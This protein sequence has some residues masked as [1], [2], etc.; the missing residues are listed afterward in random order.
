MTLKPIIILCTALLYWSSSFASHP[1]EFDAIY[2]LKKFGLDSATAH[3]SFSKQANGTWLYKS[4]TETRGLVSLFRKDKISEQSILKHRKEI[5]V[6]ILYEYRHS[7]SKKNRD[8]SIN[9]DWDNLQA[10]SVVSGTA[11]SLAITDG[12]IDGFSL[13]LKLMNDL[14][15]GKQPLV[16]RV[17]HKGEIKHYE[18]EI[19]GNETIE[20]NAGE[21]KTLKLKRSR[22]DSKRTTIMWTAP[23]LHY[24]PVKIT[25]IEKDDSH[26]T[27]LLES[28]SGDITKKH[29]ETQANVSQLT[30]GTS[31]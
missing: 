21:F 18:F 26:F 9:F 16:Y 30:Y 31:D 5:I 4:L 27:L 14:Q 15:A 13:Q 1:P 25:H 3:T 17:L 7:G 12:V 19:L 23:A 2:N 29:R 6:P 24:F 11:S 28:I 22:K 8:R 10:G 20:T